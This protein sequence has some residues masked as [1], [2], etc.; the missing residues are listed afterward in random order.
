MLQSAD[1]VTWLPT[2]VSG[3]VSL[4]LSMLALVGI[5]VGYG[6]WLE[7]LNG[8]GRRVGELETA[9]T[10][11]FAEHELFKASI[12]RLLSEQAQLI[13]ELGKHERNT[14]ACRE[15]TANLGIALGSK[16]VELTREVGRLNLDLSTRLTKVETVLVE[17]N[18]RQ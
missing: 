18:G 4:T 6:K 13:K 12:N 1:Q 14:E 11:A 10:M 17:R 3:Y 9:K 16:I 8:M 5:A 2:T 15:D 7:K